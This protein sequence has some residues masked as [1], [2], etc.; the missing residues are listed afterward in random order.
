MAYKADVNA[1]SFDGAT[2]LSDAASRGFKDVVEVLLANKAEVNVKDTLEFT[3]LH[4]AVLS[5]KKD[6]VKLLLGTKRIS[7][8]RMETV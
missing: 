5:G 3:P 4:L 1:R 7:P 6:V 8:R 2:P